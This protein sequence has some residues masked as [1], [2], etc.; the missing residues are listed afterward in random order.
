MATSCEERLSEALERLAAAEA[1]LAALELSV[2][3]LRDTIST[4]DTRQMTPTT[5]LELLEAKNKAKELDIE[6]KTLENLDKQAHANLLQ[7][8]ANEKTTNALKQL[9]RVMGQRV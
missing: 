9:T 5:A 2:K 3:E 8:E 6:A 1:R 4:A 7:S